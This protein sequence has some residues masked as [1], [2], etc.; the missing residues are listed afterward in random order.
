MEI[1][2]W[3]VQFTFRSVE[4]LLDHLHLKTSLS[5]FSL[6][7]S[8]VTSDI[9]TS[10]LSEHSQRSTFCCAYYLI[11]YVRAL[12]SWSS[13]LLSWLP[14]SA[15]MSI[16]IDHSFTKTLILYEPSPLPPSLAIMFAYVW[17]KYYAL[18]V[19]A[20]AIRLFLWSQLNLWEVFH[21]SITKSALAIAY[22]L[23][24]DLK[25][26]RTASKFRQS[27]V[28]FWSGYG[29]QFWVTRS[30]QSTND[31]IRQHCNTAEAY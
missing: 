11:F 6:F 26:S 28:R 22:N 7:T 9:Y 29:L 3:K 4:A 16:A 15:A 20:E 10:S 14:C 25:T 8:Y 13:I 12:K 27:I 5:G 24:F 17:W 19:S 1:Q 18:N 31:K 23:S 21:T 30:R 2:W